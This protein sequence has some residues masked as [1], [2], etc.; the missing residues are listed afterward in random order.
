MLMPFCLYPVIDLSW[1]KVFD[2]ALSKTRTLFLCSL[3]FYFCSRFVCFL[4]S[5]YVSPLI[6]YFRFKTFLIHWKL[7][8]LL[9]AEA[10]L[11]QTFAI[12]I[13]ILFYCFFSK[14]K[15]RHNWLRSTIDFMVIYMLLYSF[16]SIQVE[17]LFTKKRKHF[18]KL[19]K[20]LSLSIAIRFTNA[21]F[22]TAQHW[23]E[24][25]KNEN[26]NMD[27]LV[28]ISWTYYWMEKILQ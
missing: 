27:F 5:I 28:N 13:C 25:F 12:F 20:L 22:S 24:K 23:A 4:F 11:I 18:F 3:C 17:F 26:K 14:K 7:N 10:S 15:N 2:C 6:L 19:N 9:F 16:N 8:L 1:L 21:M